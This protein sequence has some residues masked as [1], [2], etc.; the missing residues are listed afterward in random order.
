MLALTFI[1]FFKYRQNWKLAVGVIIAGC[2]VVEVLS[3]RHFYD[4]IS[5]FTFNANTAWYRGRLI[6]VALFEGGMSGHWLTGFGFVDPRWTDLIDHRN[7]TDIVNHYLVILCR[8]GL[9]GFIPFVLVVKEMIKRLVKAYK[10]C[11]A[12]ADQW[13]IWCLGGQLYGLFG[14]M[15]SVSL[16]GQPRTFFYILIGIAGAMPAFFGE[17]VAQGAISRTVG[18]RS[19]RI[20]P[21]DKRYAMAH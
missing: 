7:H 14:A 16:F 4:V 2:L 11:K 8:F 3:N 9:V 6:E 13:L 18:A 1:L 10:L 5:R 21:A 17:T 19:R 15:F 20:R 12:E